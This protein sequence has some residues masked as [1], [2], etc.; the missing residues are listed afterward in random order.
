[1]HYLYSAFQDAQSHFTK[2]KGTQD[3]PLEILHTVLT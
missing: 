3:Q 1:M 2:V